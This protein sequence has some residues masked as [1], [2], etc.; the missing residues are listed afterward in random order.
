MPKFTKK[1]LITLFSILGFGCLFQ[2]TSAQFASLPMSDLLSWY[3]QYSSIYYHFGGN[4][5]GWMIFLSGVSIITWG[6]NIYIN[7]GNQSLKC[8][9][10]LKGLYYNNLRG[11]RLRPLDTGSFQTLIARDSNYNSLSIG[12]GLYTNCTGAGAKS[13]EIYGQITHQWWGIEY[14]I[15]AGL[16]MSLTWNYI[17]QPGIFAWSLK[18][19]SGSVDWILYDTHGGAGEVWPVTTAS[20]G[21][22]IIMGTSQ[23]S[24]ASQCN[25]LKI[26]AKS[27]TNVSL[28]CSGTNVTDYILNIFESS[29]GNIIQSTSGP[30]S[31]FPRTVSIPEGDYIA[32]CTT[33][34]GNS[35]CNQ[36]AISNL[37]GELFTSELGTGQ[38]VSS[39]WIT[40]TITPIRHAKTKTTYT[41]EDI[42]VRGLTAPTLA[43]ISK[44]YLTINWTG[45]GTTGYVQNG[46]ILT[47]ELISSSGYNS[48]V[49]SNV[50]IGGIFGVFS[51]ITE[52]NSG[53]ECA[54]SNTE[55]LKVA[56][57][58]ELIKWG[59]NST[60]EKRSNMLYVLQSMTQDIQ[61]FDYN[62]S[63][64]YL[65]DLTNDEIENGSSSSE[66]D[67]SA[68][69]APNCKEY[70][71]N[72]DDTAASYTSSDFKKEQLFASREALIRFID[73]QNPGDC[74]VNVYTNETFTYVDTSTTHAAPNG[75]IYT[76]ESTTDGLFSSPT[77][78][79]QKTFD[80]K[81]GLIT[82]IDKYNPQFPIRDH[83]VDTS[84][85]PIT[86]AT[87]NGKEYK[88]YKT[89]KGY[90]SYKLIKIKYFE[91]KDAI[92]E[93]IDKNNK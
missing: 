77:M 48:T 80:S 30:S 25:S 1:I 41:S 29:W 71:V 24:M 91:S 17:I 72:Y 33:N 45:V 8:T 64:Q 63:L 28:S 26:T 14:D 66:G 87:A 22:I 44:G 68:H 6:E 52:D 83:T 61:D 86:Y 37:S 49:S 78:T 62:C 46:D 53:N 43:T 88:I 4:N 59:Y 57:M 27:G 85:G 19:T 21:N 16:A 74:H 90:M 39:I 69:T 40:N 75:K 51:V 76:I 20:G 32:S 18:I 50:F 47:I 11:Q 23:W 82:Y 13:N 55:K 38:V 81:E 36:I 9:Y 79:K 65:M 70:A 12:G 10:K 34:I 42:V 60:P 2:Q 15:T 35:S 93:Y 84:R 92:I 5:F 54:L 7:W 73:S 56:Q 3:T 58:F 67:E 89:N 31:P